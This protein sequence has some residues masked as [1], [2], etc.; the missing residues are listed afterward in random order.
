[1]EQISSP[2]LVM[3]EIIKVLNTQHEINN[4]V[5]D[6]N[7]SYETAMRTFRTEAEKQGVN[8]PPEKELPLLAYNRSIL[9]P[10][11]DAVSNNRLK[12]N[13]HHMLQVEGEEIAD[14]AIIH[15][16]AHAEFEFRFEVYFA[17]IFQLERFEVNWVTN[18]EAPN[19]KRIYIDTFSE[20]GF[21]LPYYL[22]YE[23]LESKQFQ[24]DNILQ[25]SL[26]G[27]IV[28]R[29]FYPTIIGTHP[30]IKTLQ[31]RIRD[32]KEVYFTCTEEISHG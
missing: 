4:L 27:T 28:V 6:E 3:R 11:Q 18:L 25:K 13:K 31:L 29:G 5:Y 23:P 16:I 15:R 24:R 32:T 17:D 22:S 14:N 21:N 12:I 26:T 8:I 30:L 19:A 9:R 7:F 10:Y 2:V 20:I 1:M